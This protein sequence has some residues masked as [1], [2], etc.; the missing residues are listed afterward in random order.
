MRNF[1]FLNTTKI[2]FGRGVDRKVGKE[3]KN[4]GGSRILLHH[5][6]DNVIK[7]IGLYDR[8]IKSLQSEGLEIIELSGVLPNPRLSLVKEGIKICKEANVDFVLAVGG[9]SVIDSAKV[10]SLGLSYEGDVWDFFSGKETNEVPSILPVGVVLTIPASGSESHPGAVITNEDGWQKRGYSSSALLPRFAFLNPENTFSLPQYQTACGISDIISHLMERYF[11]QEQDVGLTDILIESL[12]K[13]VINNSSVVMKEPLD[14]NA[15]SEIML[16]GTISHNGLLGIGRIEDWASH[17]IEHE[18]S[19]IY[20]I[21]HGAGLAII[22]PAWMKYV[23]KKNIDRFYRFAVNIWDVE[24]DPGSLESIAF[25]GIDR[26]IKFLRMIGLPTT[27]KEAKIPDDRF[28]EIAE[29]CTR[30]GKIGNFE[31]L[32]KKDVLNILDLSR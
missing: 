3:I 4:F 21:A 26:Y 6:A 7:K 14:Y 8:I 20:D 9:G 31:K 29:K 30:S 27:F 24:P 16:A 10:I 17:G 25:K 23:Y 15:R 28:D 12:Y 18:I 11:T 32:N 13:I 5:Y 1:E 2:I 22:F 19:A